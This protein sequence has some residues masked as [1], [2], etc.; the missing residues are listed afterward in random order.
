MEPKPQAKCGCTPERRRSHDIGSLA[1]MDAYVAGL[2]ID[3]AR[4]VTEACK[5][6]PARTYYLLEDGTVR[7]V[8]AGRGRRKAGVR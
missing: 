5:A 3:T 8:A 2:D 6:D 1:K 7:E 4:A